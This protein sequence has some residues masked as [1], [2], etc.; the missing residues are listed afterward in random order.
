MVSG[1]PSHSCIQFALR[2]TLTW[3]WYLSF[4]CW[5]LES[6]HRQNGL[7]HP[8]C[9]HYPVISSCSWKLPF[10]TYAP[11]PCLLLHNLVF[12]TRIQN[13]YKF[14]TVHTAQHPPQIP[15]EV[16]LIC[17]RWWQVLRALRGIQTLHFDGRMTANTY[18]L[19][20]SILKSR[21]I[22][23]VIFL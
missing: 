3:C 21:Q 17:R 8:L 13:G 12:L 7:D 15:T 16:Y 18:V 19:S 2:V 6:P 20:S 10:S 1:H 11:V 9:C 4:N 14:C 22:W 23:V 5:S